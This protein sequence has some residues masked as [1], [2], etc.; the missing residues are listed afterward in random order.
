MGLSFAGIVLLLCRWG[1]SV[2]CPDSVSYVRFAQTGVLR[3]LPFHHGIGYPLVLRLLTWNGDWLSAT[4]LCNAL[5]G[6]LSGFL[7]T[8]WFLCWFGRKG[9]V[10]ALLVLG[11]Y[12]ILQVHATVMS[13]PLFLTCLI[14]AFSSYWHL[15]DTRSPL[16]A[17]LVFFSLAFACLVRYAAIPFVAA[18]ACLSA[19]N[20]RNRPRSLLKASL[21]FLATILP[22]AIVL[23]TN[24]VVHGSATNRILTIHVPT[25]NQYGDFASVLASWIM[26][27]RIWLAF[28]VIVKIVVPVVILA[29]ATLGFGAI[30]KSR[31]PEMALAVVPIA[32]YLAFLVFSFTFFDANIPFDQRMLSP[33]PLFLVALFMLAWTLS[34]KTK[35]RWAFLVAALGLLAFDGIR[36]VPF[37]TRH[38]REGA[39]FH[40]PGFRNSAFL[41]R[42]KTLTHGAP[43]YASVSTPLH[44]HGL[45]NVRGFP[46]LSDSNSLR[47]N[48]N[49]DTDYAEMLGEIRNG[50]ALVVFLS[51][52][53]NSR[54]L[55]LERVVADAPLVLLEDYPEG[56]IYGCPPISSRS[57]PAP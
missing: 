4:R 21:F 48:P 46:I 28:P 20:S 55:P 18:I 57:P 30:K 15:M 27:D 45:S 26:P 11:N 29:I 1:A 56:T 34:G 49:F 50:G 25:Q 8:H 42:V 6:F 24:H 2:F 33:L 41:A 32:F 52:P 53:A 39:G 14:L 19:F 40:A 51:I 44:A 3:D 47:E 16:H 38:Y 23:T 36:A 54:A 22:L 43:V 17:A 12:A 9:L 10:G 13:E 35:C 7:L 5:C 37:V 31:F